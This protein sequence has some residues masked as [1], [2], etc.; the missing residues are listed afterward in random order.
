MKKALSLIVFVYLLFPAQA[1][2]SCSIAWEHSEPDLV[3]GSC[4]GSF[5]FGREL[6]KMSFFTSICQ[7]AEHPIPTSPVATV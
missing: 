4:V 1:L 2:G 3:S 5:L 7:T 6:R